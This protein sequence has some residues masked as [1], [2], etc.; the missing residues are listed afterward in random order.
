MSSGGLTL[1]GTSYVF[2]ALTQSSAAITVT[3]VHTAFPVLRDLSQGSL[4]LAGGGTA[5]ASQVRHIDGSSLIVRDGVTLALP[6]VTEYRHAST[7]DGQQR[8]LRAEGAG[9]LL[10]LGGVQTIL[11]GTQYNSRIEIAATAG[12]VVNLDAVRSISDPNEGDLREQSCDILADGTGS[13]IELSDLFS[14][15]DRRGNA[16]AGWDRWSTMAARNGGT[17]Q[18]EQLT[19]LQGTQLVLDGSGT[20]SVAQLQRMS[21]GGLTLSGTSYV[22][23]AL[24]QSIAAITVTGVHTAFPVLRDLSQGSLTL[25]GGGTADASQVRHIDGSSLIVRDGVTL[26]LLL[27]T[28]YRHASTTDGQQRRL[29]A[30]GAGSL[31]DLGGV[32]TI[33][34]GTHYNSRIEIAATAGGV[35]NL[36][37]VRSISDP[38]EGDLREQSFDI[39]A[40]GT[41]S[42]IELSDL[43]SVVDRRGNATAGWDR[44]STMAAR[45][46]GTIQA[47]QLTHL[48]GTQLVLDGSGTQSVA[49]LQRMSS[50][51][52]TLSGT[53]YVLSGADAIER[54]DHGH[55]RAHSIP[56][57]ARSESGQ[58]DAG[59]RWH[60]RCEPGAPHRRQLADR[61][62]RRDARAAAGDGVPPRLDHRRATA[63]A[64]PKEQAA[65]WTWAACR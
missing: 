26:A 64:A 9:S 11:G 25:A 46:G 59:G 14:F 1:S 63:A 60:R 21:S 41:G 36:D 61:A 55:G 53:S 23:P 57:A 40:D 16:T 31:L 7:T 12:G 58:P 49:Q 51:G 43:F 62:G 22:F 27:V 32:Q 52:L 65:C 4:T 10:D 24:T 34:G 8:R 29:R 42:R 45:N 44:W 38:N 39:L 15:V 19:Q 17:I 18:A 20:Q 5:D 33:L 54:R 56:R 6:L 3:G 47:E 13:R 48:Q 28:E 2:P 30:E 35:V 37:A 50:G